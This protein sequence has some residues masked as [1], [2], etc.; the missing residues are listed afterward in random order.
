MKCSFK[1]EN[2]C[3]KKCLIAF[4][5]F[6]VSVLVLSLVVKLV[7]LVLSWFFSDLYLNTIVVMFS[8]VVV[9]IAAYK[10][11][12]SKYKKCCNCQ[13]ELNDCCE[14]PEAKSEESGN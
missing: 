12:C 3:Y 7:A 4:I 8:S 2:N 6:V 1:N 11:C 5:C 10:C 13:K 9:L 14:K